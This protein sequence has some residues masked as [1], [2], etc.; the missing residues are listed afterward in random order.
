[1][2]CGNDNT[3]FSGKLFVGGVSWKTSEAEVRTHFEQFGELVDAVLIKNKQTGEPRGFGFV[4]FKDHIIAT[5]VLGETHTLNGR[6]VD[7]KRAVP[8]DHQQ[9]APLSQPLT[10]HTGDAIHSTATGAS[11]EDARLPLESSGCHLNGVSFP[12]D[13]GSALSE[14]CFLRTAIKSMH[15]KTNHAHQIG[16]AGMS[17][18]SAKS[19]GVGASVGGTSGLINPKSELQSRKIFVGGLAATV[20]DGEF[21]SYF[22]RFGSIC[23]AVV[24][25]DR[26]THRSRG[27]GFIT[28]FSE[29]AVGR[30]M[31]SKHE[32]KGKLVEIKHAEPKDSAQNASAIS[33]SI[34]H[35]HPDGSAAFVYGMPGL[36]LQQQQ[37]HTQCALEREIS[38]VGASPVPPKIM[39]AMALSMK[40]SS[41]DG[42]G[43]DS[44]DRAAAARVWTKGSNVDFD[45]PPE[46]YPPQQVAPLEANVVSAGRGNGEEGEK[47]NTY[48]PANSM[49]HSITSQT[50]HNAVVSAQK[51]VDSQ[52]G[53]HKNNSIDKQANQISRQMGSHGMTIP[54]VSTQLNTSAMMTRLR[55]AEDARAEASHARK[56]A[57]DEV[58]HLATK[59]ENQELTIEH[60][61][62]RLE[63]QKD[64]SVR[65]VPA[66]QH[67]GTDS[68][69]V[70]VAAVAEAEEMT[71][72]AETK[73]EAAELK[74]EDANNRLRAAEAKMNEQARIIHELEFANKIDQARADAAEGRVGKIAK[75]LERSEMNSAKYTDRIV[76]LEDEVTGLRE[77]LDAICDEKGSEGNL[78]ISNRGKVCDG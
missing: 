52:L 49:K 19:P 23:D 34:I 59:L 32:L 13:N 37:Q 54:V 64:Q 63:N 12:P 24:M 29:I 10:N 3:E 35:Q 15:P 26:K 68:T 53:S 18:T 21:R 33:G 40:D 51:G 78:S 66:A 76:A 74:T 77:R 70:A 27:F 71:I 57:E 58:L 61:E 20:T 65:S 9:G 60:L 5:R 42:P 38:V 16:G 39:T 22:E 6:T 2:S 56:V 4:E 25:F 30:V 14:D 28:Y 31:A 1:M 72:A 67:I 50:N 7:L 55:M 73:A 36:G 17:G 47:C 48:T 69:S 8:R 45:S 11:V 46:Q 41:V 75:A 62:D 44:D 43:H